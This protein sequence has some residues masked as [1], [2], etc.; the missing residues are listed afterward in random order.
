GDRRRRARSPRCGLVVQCACGHPLADGGD[1]VGRQAP[2]SVERRARTALRHE[3]AGDVGPPLDLADDVAEVRLAG[4]TT[5]QGRLLGRLHVDGLAVGLTHGQVHGPRR[6]GPDVAPRQGAGAVEDG[7]DVGG[8]GDRG[9]RR[10]LAGRLRGTP[11]A[12]A[13]AAGA[14]GQQAG[15]RQQGDLRRAERPHPL[16]LG[17]A[18]LRGAGCALLAHGGLEIKKN[19]GGLYGVAL[20]RTRMARRTSSARDWTFIF[21]MTC[22]RCTSTVFS[23]RPRSMAMTLLVLP[24]TTSS[25]T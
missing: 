3:N 9:C 25:I 14:C 2:G 6:D 13:A 21:S 11:S 7:L 20:G 22:A 23:Q 18:P 12:T 19:G 24:L 10:R 5:L 1:V 8:E 16:L 17:T 15:N 4:E